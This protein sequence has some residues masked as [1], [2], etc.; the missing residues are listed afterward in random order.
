MGPK[1]RSTQPLFDGEPPMDPLR[2]E[3]ERLSGEIRRHDQLYYVEG[4]PE[5]DDAA[6]DTLYRR[7]VEI[8]RLHPEWVVPSSPTQR[9][10]APIPDGS[11]FARVEHE[12]PMLSIDSLF[13]EEEVRDFEKGIVRFLKLESGAELEWAL[14]P[15]FDGVSA[16]L[17]YADGLLVRGA[18][19]GDGSVGEDITNNLRTVRNIPLALDARQ[20]PV[21]RLLEVRGEVLIHREK[22]AEF[23]RLRVSEGLAPLANPRNATAGAL[24]RNDP[25]EVARYPLEFHSWSVVRVQLEEA[26][27]E[28]AFQS[29]REMLAALRQW[30]L[31]DSGYGEV[32]RGLDGALDYH[33]RFEAKRFE[34]PFDVDGVVAKLDSLEL[35]ER[36]GRTSRAHRWQ[37]AHKFAPVEA[38][39]TLRAIEVQVGAGGRLT[40]RA[41]LDP[42]EVAGVTVQHTT[43]HN[44]DHVASLGLSIGDRVYIHRAGDVIPQVIGVA[45]QAQG[46]APSDWEDRVPATLRD[47]SGAVR[48]GVAWR[49]REVFAMPAKCPACASESVEEGKYW[50]CPN[51][52]ACP[53]Q[54]VGRVEIVVSRA[55]FEIEGLGPK[56]I[57]QLVEHGLLRSPA[58]V[59]HLKPED[60]LGLERWAEKS[61]QN[62]MEQIEARRAVPL[63]RFL[64]ALAIPEVGPATARLLAAHFGSLDGLRAATT[65]DLVAVD[66]IGTEV[67]RRITEWFADPAGAALIERFLE[68]GVELQ[69][70]SSPSGRALVGRTFVLTGTLEGLSRA[71]AKRR[72]EDLGG[73]VSSDVSA[74]TDYLVAGAS[75]G[76][77]LKRA[78]ELGVTILDEAGLRALADATGMSKDA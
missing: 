8:E 56:L 69:A 10:G 78:K 17:V 6:Y 19:R 21:P 5:I 67:A 25:K 50:F 73:R 49:W 13:T 75:P 11:G 34:L 12:V 51:G 60:L 55:A 57:A 63:A 38:Q 33:R 71:E 24:R 61:V 40:P 28:A 52:L 18:T 53:P 2:A 45:Q 42:V 64:V 30:G 14:E 7:L 41:H 4:R 37:Y 22:L 15:K 70:P 77:K 76:S 54:L 16:S 47:A 31:P 35:R 32:V 39:T 59:F 62:L 72:I 29:H 44:A 43:L 27:K 65:E 1:K 9:V 66:G 46:A 68:G 48:P 36:L 74:R 23:N 58:D 26:S 3:L 20:R